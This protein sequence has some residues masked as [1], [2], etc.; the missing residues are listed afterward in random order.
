M[1]QQPTL[2]IEVR[3]DVVRLRADDE[4]DV[5]GEPDFSEG[6]LRTLEELRSQGSPEEYG[7]QLLRS[8]FRDGARD[9]YRRAV[10]KAQD[11]RWALRLRLP[12]DRRLNAIWWEGLFDRDTPAKWLA[13][14]P[15]TPLS[16]YLRPDG[17]PPVEQ[18]TLRVLAVISD[19]QDLGSGDLAHVERLDET[20]EREIIDAALRRLG[21][22]VER[23]VLTEPASRATIR[24][25]L[26]DGPSGEGEGFHVLHLVCPAFVEPGEEGQAHVILETDDQKADVCN[27]DELQ[28]LVGGLEEL[29]LVVLAGR[30]T[31]GGRWGNALLQMGPGL[32]ESGV[33]AVVAMQ[34]RLPADIAGT[35]AQI[36]YGSLGKS[37]RTAGMVDTAVNDARDRIFGRI[38][39]RSRWD[40]LMPVLFMRGDGQLFRPPQTLERPDVT[41]GGAPTGIE[42][43]RRDAPQPKE[44]GTTSPSWNLREAA[45]LPGGQFNVN[46]VV[47]PITGEEVNVTNRQVNT[48]GGDI[49]GQVNLG[50]QVEMTQTIQQ[51]NREEFGAAL[52][53]VLAALKAAD[54]QDEKAKQGIS[55]LEVAKM[56]AAAGDEPS[57]IRSRLERA[58]EFLDGTQEV[59]KKGLEI[60]ELLKKAAKLVGAVI[61]W[62]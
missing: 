52:D 17:R 54:P 11:A 7:W 1:S 32:I 57:E 12:S 37:Q 43:T 22:R 15:N 44:P 14:Y 55:Q 10:R 5:D 45:S 6:S 62:L 60:G 50:D 27:V 58:G 29:R 8:L 13:C 19:P 3:P 34:D 42:P 40:W 38:R 59:V 16:R 18:E 26:K 23:R 53:Q 39:D 4:D 30:H 28:W 49:G 41:G 25:W 47:N 46:V 56:Q 9:A 20:V 31:G 21:D 35:F 48:G 33:P 36:F 2:E 61:A 51:F 24:D